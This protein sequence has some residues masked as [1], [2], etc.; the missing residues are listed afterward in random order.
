MEPS[1]IQECV[2]HTTVSPLPFNTSRPEC[3]SGRMSLL[4]CR[5]SLRGLLSGF[6]VL[7]KSYDFVQW[8][9]ALTAFKSSAVLTS[10]Q[11]S[12][13]PFFSQQSFVHLVI[14]CLAKSVFSLGSESRYGEPNDAPFN[15]R[16]RAWLAVTKGIL[17]PPDSIIQADSPPHEL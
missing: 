15:A 3:H 14:F 2:S 1:S 12:R 4:P 17:Q 10:A 16:F 5:I 8:P 6:S 9:F 11:V 13:S 7:L